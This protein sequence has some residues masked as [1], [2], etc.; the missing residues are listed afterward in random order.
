MRQNQDS[1]VI[2]VV[3]PAILVLGT[4]IW[5]GFDQGHIKR[6]YGEEHIGDS[7]LPWVLGCVLLW[8]LFFPL[9]LVTRSAQRRGEPIP[10]VPAVDVT[11]PRGLRWHRDTSGLWFYWQPQAG[12]V[13]F[14]DPANPRAPM[15]E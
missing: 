8:I 13:R 6:T 5:V 14:P 11:D 1:M 9:Y 15:P 10:P 12:W 3:C 2:A 7:W 4:T